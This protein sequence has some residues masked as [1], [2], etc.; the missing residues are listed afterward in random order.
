MH[1]TG[2]KYDK[3][4]LD[5]YTGEPSTVDVYR[6]LDAFEVTSQPRGHAIKKALNAGQRGK[7]GEFEDIV[8]AIDALIEDAIILLDKARG[9]DE[10]AERLSAKHMQRLAQLRGK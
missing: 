5:K 3:T 7:G 8:E 6:V 4:I 9:S 2:S 1:A 10:G